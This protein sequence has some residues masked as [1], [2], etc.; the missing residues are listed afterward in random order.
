MKWCPEEA[1]QTVLTSEHS[2]AFL[3]LFQSGM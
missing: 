2:C 3:S 1:P